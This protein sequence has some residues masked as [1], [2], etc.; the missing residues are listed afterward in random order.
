MAL[1][2]DDGQS[3]GSLHLC[4]EFDVGTTARHV[5]GY[6]HGTQQALL[7]VYVCGG[8]LIGMLG[9]FFCLAYGVVSV[10]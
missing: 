8:I 7:L 1:G 2:A 6:G 9:R 4:R 10:A 3:T 5:G